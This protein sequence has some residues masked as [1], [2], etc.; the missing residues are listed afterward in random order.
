[1]SNDNKQMNI[2]VIGSGMYVCGRSTDG[3]GTIIPA[4][5]E[6]GKNNKIRNLY[7][8]GTDP[9][10]IRIAK[11]KIDELKRDMSVKITLEY[12]PKGNAKNLESYKEAIRKIPKPACAVIVVPDNLHREI[13]GYAIENGLHTLVV[14]PLAPT[15][16]EVQELINIQE[17]SGVYCSVEFHKRFDLAN[18]KLKDVILE[19]T[20]GDPLRFL[21][22]YSQRRSV[23]T[24]HF[25]KWV[26]KTNVFQYLGI[27]Y[28]DIIH[29]VTH[30][31]PKRAMAIGQK[32]WLITQGVNTY[33]AVQGTIEWEMP[34][35][36]KF[37]SYILTSWVDPENTSAMSDQRIKAVGS[38]GSFVSDQKNRGITIV[39]DKNGTEHPNPYFCA[40]YGRKGDISYKGYGI[41]SVCQFLND[42][43]QVVKGVLKPEDLEAKRPTFKESLIPTAVLEAV[44]KSLEKSGEWVTVDLRT[45]KHEYNYNTNR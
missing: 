11:D 19:G 40:P 31:I 4:I 32:G 23:P 25:K 44:N 12:F 7:I 35:G 15:L 10:G 2:L 43:T 5:F 16:R 36:K 33:D 37:L 42:V 17:K 14:K 29:F 21:V 22:E 24:K 20:I 6:W 18:Q 3:Y 30:A 41:E 27:H 45:K 28:V 9:E 34:G 8:A 13:A 39:T 38:K 1:M 26:T